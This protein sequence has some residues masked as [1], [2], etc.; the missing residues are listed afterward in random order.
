M[1]KYKLVTQLS[2]LWLSNQPQLQFIYTAPRYTALN[3]IWYV[4]ERYS[5]GICLT[6]IPILY[7]INKTRALYKLL[8][9]DLPQT[10]IKNSDLETIHNTL[11]QLR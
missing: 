7:F 11:Q 5:S 10:G 6:T 4:E 2:Y 3:R 1:N 8:Q 9:Y